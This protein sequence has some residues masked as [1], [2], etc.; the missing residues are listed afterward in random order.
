[1]RIGRSGQ[2][3][4]LFGTGFK[5]FSI[6]ERPCV[7]QATCSALL[8]PWVLLK[9]FSGEWEQGC[10]WGLHVCGVGTGM[11]RAKKWGEGFEPK[12]IPI[13]RS[14]HQLQTGSREGFLS[15]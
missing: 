5:S 3:L 1:M 15:H 6:A 9:G 2:I 4:G 7:L 11:N 13:H 12:L 10:P 14:S 8:L